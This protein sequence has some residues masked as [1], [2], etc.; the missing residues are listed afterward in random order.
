VSDP[1][2][3]NNQIPEENAGMAARGSNK[4]TFLPP[5]A[6]LLR[7]DNVSTTFHT[8]RGD[9]RAVSNIS[10]EVRS[11]EVVGIVGESGSGKTVLSRTL[12]G[13][14]PR[15]GVTVDG[16]ITF[17]KRYVAERG[18]A[19][20]GQVPE[21]PLVGFEVARA[22]ESDLRTVWG[23]EVA[24]VFQDPMTS[25][26]PVQRVGNQISEGLRVRQGMSKA[27][28]K[29][30]A[31]EL[32]TQVGIPSPEERYRAYPNQ[33]SGGMR[34]RVMIAIALA[35]N[36]RLLLA[37]EPTTGLDVTIQAQILNLLEDLQRRYHM[38]VLLVTH[39]LG[40]VATRTDRIVVM[41][42]GRVVE[43]GNTRD[44][45]YGHRMPYTEALLKST[46]KISNSSHSRLQTI[47][48]RPPDIL[49]L[50]PGCS[51]APRCSYATEKCHQERPELEATENEG[52]FFACW[53][54]LPARK[55]PPATRSDASEIGVDS[56]RD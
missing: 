17:A 48:G 38:S 39:D 9:V 7:V 46:P 42:G 10:F 14:Q 33:L 11:N 53:N 4:I 20:D 52:H 26:N 55:T 15:H 34:Q 51:F 25:L 29:K 24:M 21:N 31:I 12:M 22:K 45:F 47:P 50:P 30:R 16:S 54:P 35:C 43:C 18:D 23:V 2:T 19:I 41:Y 32:L 6:P 40:V 37:D 56:V 3:P 5:D 49:N 28:A 13:L 27:D 8:P 1:Q 44:V 36:P